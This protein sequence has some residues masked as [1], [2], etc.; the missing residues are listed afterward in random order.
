MPKNNENNA[1]II[2][3]RKDFSEIKNLAYSLDYKVLKLFFQNRKKPEVNYY[4]GKGK[5]EEIKEFVLNKNM[6]IDLIIIDGKLNPSQWFNLEKQFGIIVYDRIRLIL[7]IFKQ[8]ADK[9]EPKLQVRLA[10]LQYEKPFV[11]E[12]INRARSG[13]HPGFMAGGEYQ[14]DDY[15]E[16][17]KKQMKKIKIDLEKIREKREI[18]RDNRHLRGFYLLALAGYTN[19]GKSSILNLLSNDKIFVEDKLF[20][21]L[22]TTSRRIINKKIP[23]LL[24]DTV[25]F[26]D[27]LPTWMI[28]AFHSTL[29]EIEVA[30]LVLL[31][32]DSSD[33]F[34][35]FKRKFYSSFNE[36]MEIGVES[37]ILIILN[38]I[39]LISKA[40]LMRKID[41]LTSLEYSLNKNVIPI[42]VKFGLNIKELL[43]N[44]YKSLPNIV[45]F[46]IKLISNV[47]TQSLI[48]WIYNRAYVSDISYINNYVHIKIECN[49]VIKNI[50]LSKCKNQEGFEYIF[51]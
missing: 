49:E 17:I 36:L 15:Y 13:E 46:K 27:R 23:I 29:E 16:M 6:T 26:I 33:S 5:I 28:N 21:T 50:I 47:K 10:E 39:D 34:E 44:I 40:N 11:K 1:I 45:K 30:D 32:V 14:V 25:G 43:N 22:S 41:Y 8:R 42:S 9:K 20:S 35:I 7:E 37:S 19:A 38:K 48:N 4:I 18:L 12:L 2:S 51:N 24:T 31:V 3:I